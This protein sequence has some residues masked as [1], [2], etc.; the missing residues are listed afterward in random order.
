MRQLVTGI[1]LL[2]ATLNASA[3]SEEADV[4]MDAAL[5]DY[6]AVAGGWYLNERCW[7]LTGGVKDNF[8]ENLELINLALVRDLGR[9]DALRDIQRASQL[10]AARPPYN[11]CGAEA[12][13]VVKSTS[14]HAASWAE[15]IRKLII[16]LRSKQ[17]NE[18]E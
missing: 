1:L 17:E 10:A 18:A 13:E 12:D 5:R 4:A 11:A 16:E 7:F 3:Q 15:E 6:S 2:T 9:T 8:T 14:T